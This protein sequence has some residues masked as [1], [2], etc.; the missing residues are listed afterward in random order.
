MDGGATPPG[1]APLTGTWDGE[2][3]RRTG[4]LLGTPREEAV[5]PQRV[6]LALVTP[7][8]ILTVYIGLLVIARGA[9]GAW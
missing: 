8:A 6:I 1:S 9:G 3:P 2:T 5:M 4:H 7:W